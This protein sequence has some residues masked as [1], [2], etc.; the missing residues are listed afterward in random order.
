MHTFPLAILLSGKGGES[1]MENKGIDSCGAERPDKWK[2]RRG[3][4]GGRGATDGAIK[5]RSTGG[6]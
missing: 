1:E 2:G 5:R 4:G 3:G 6:T